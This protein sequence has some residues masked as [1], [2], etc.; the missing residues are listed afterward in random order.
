[1]PSDTYFTRLSPDRAGSPN[2][3]RRI[4][5]DV[6]YG[7]SFYVCNPG[8]R[9]R[10]LGLDLVLLPDLLDLSAHSRFPRSSET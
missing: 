10:S 2:H 8:R 4:C 1:M 7:D 6:F 5:D 3:L 9:H